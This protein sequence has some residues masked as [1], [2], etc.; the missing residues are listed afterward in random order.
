V[1][2]Y[3]S[4]LWHTDPNAPAILVAVAAGIVGLINIAILYRDLT[5]INKYTSLCSF[6]LLLPSS[7][8]HFHSFFFHFFRIGTVLFGILIFVVCFVSITGFSKF[9]IDTFHTPPVQPQQPIQNSNWHQFLELANAT[10]VAVYDFSG[11]YEIC[12][13]G[14][15]VANPGY[16]IPKAVVGSVFI[17]VCLF[18]MVE[19]SV[20]GVVPW[21]EIRDNTIPAQYPIAYFLEAAF[22]AAINW[23]PYV[24]VILLVLTVYGSSF[25]L[26]LGYSRIPYAAAKDGNFFRIFGRLHKQGFPHISLLIMGLL[27]V[28]CCFFRLET[29]VSALIT[30][31]ILVQYIAQ[32]VGLSILRRRTDLTYTYKVWLYPLPNLIAAVIWLFLFFSATVEVIVGT[33]IAIAVGVVLFLTW[34]FYSKN[35][36]FSPKKSTRVEEDGIN[37]NDV[38]LDY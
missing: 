11:Y 31:R 38:S 22:P 3:I 37:F 32:I 4:Y 30:A 34:S 14:S 2:Q 8:A 16:V 24:F 33:L 27:S 5:D 25:A 35:W 28:A 10:R 23:L 12:Y 19:I 18:L 36:P 6:V 20:I 17:V 13:M 15:E 1:G 21:T 29:L 26:L 7:S 9:D